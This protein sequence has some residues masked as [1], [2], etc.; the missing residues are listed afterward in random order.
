MTAP[1][2]SVLMPVY[3]GAATLGRTLDSLVG[4]GPGIEVIAVDQAS[5]DGSRALLEARAGQLDLTIIDAP[6]SRSWMRNTN[7]ALK[8]ANGPLVTMLHQDDL[9]RPG[10]AEALRL[11]AAAEPEARLWLHAAEYIDADDRV[12]GRAA[13]PFGGRARL[14]G[15]AEALT[16]LLV[17][18]TVALPAAMFRRDDALSAGGLDED[19]W[20]TADWDLWL[21]LARRGPVAWTPAPLA[22]FRVHRGSL[23][24]T[25][26]RDGQ[27]F[28]QQLEIPLAR[29]LPA[30]PEADGARVGRLARLSNELN[31]GLA[32]AYHGSDAGLRRTVLRIAALGPAGWRAFLRDTNIVGRVLPRLRLKLRKG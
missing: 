18:N 26:S 7:I 16:H 13:P 6:E 30:L 31:A 10:R 25:G 22:A 4:Q 32:G 12:I 19:L 27:A 5:S 9:W 24:V 28:R 1:W 21:S 11:M 23:T 20:Y 29:H 17:Q 15:G 3:N 8:A 2:L 14:I